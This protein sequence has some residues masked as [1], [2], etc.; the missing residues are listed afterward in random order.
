VHAVHIR[1]N[2]ELGPNSYRITVLGAPVG[3][4]EVFL[5]ESLP[6]IRGKSRAPCQGSATKDPAFGLEAF[7]SKSPGASRPRRR[8]IPWWTPAA[9]SRLI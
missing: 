1:D 9:S 2:L 5:I 8:A 6:S 4:S 7:G 3:E